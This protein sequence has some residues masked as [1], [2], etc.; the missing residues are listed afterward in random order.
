MT[1]TQIINGQ[2]PPNIQ[3]IDNKFHVKDKANI[4]YA[5]SPA[6]YN[7]DSLTIPTH[8]IVHETVHLTRQWDK[9]VEKWW[10]LYISNPVFRLDEELYAH[11]AEWSSYVQLNKDKNQQVRYL[12]F[13]CQ[14]LAGSLYDNL[15]TVKE[16]RQRILMS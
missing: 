5:Y 8:L 1:A 15:L 4:L 11:R 12:H 16:A 3:A 7:P 2:H 6:I 13:M 14:R 10:D 9:G